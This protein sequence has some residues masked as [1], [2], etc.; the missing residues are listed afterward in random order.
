LRSRLLLLLAF[1]PALANAASFEVHPPAAWIDRISVDTNAA[2]PAD[3][4]SG[5]CVLLSDHQVRVDGRH[6]TEYF[7]RVRKVLTSSGV[8]NAS[9]ASLDFDPSYQHLIIHSATV[10]RDGKSTNV[11]EPGEVRI[12]EKESES[13]D[14]IYDGELT[15]V[16]FLKDVRPGDVIDYSWS[17][18]GANPLL[19]GR[20]ADEYEISSAMTSRLIRHRLLLASSRPLHYR[21]S[22]KG[23]SPRV[24][25]HGA[26]TEYVWERRDSQAVDAEDETPEWFDPWE[27][28]QVSEFAS[29]NEIARWSASLFRADAASA[30]AVRELAATIRAKHPSQSD[31]LVAAIRFV[32]DDIRYLGIEMGRN[33][34]E[35]HQPSL[36]LKQRY[37]DCKDKSF[38]L[39]LLLRE[40]GVE[41]YPALVNTRLRHRLDDYLPSPFL[42]DHVIVKVVDRAGIH[43]VDA[44]LSEQGGNLATIDTPNDER[45]LIVR[46]DTSSLAKISTRDGGSTLVEQTYTSRGAVTD[47]VVARTY[48]GADADTMRAHLAGLS[49]AD[50][51]KDDLNRFAVDHPQL[52][53]RGVPRISDDRQRNLV[54]IEE[55]YLV[56]DLWTN[57]SWSYV[58]RAITQYLQKPSTIVRTMPLAFD[59]PLDV[60]QRIVFHLPS[61]IELQTG[62]DE[63]ITHAFRVDSD[64]K[65]EGTTITIEHRLRSLA[66]A[67]PAAAVPRHLTQIGELVDAMGYDLTLAPPRKALAS[68]MPGV[69]A[70]AVFVVLAA[71]VLA[72]RR[73]RRRT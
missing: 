10:T 68:A 51:A 56:R 3:V 16:L 46:D 14:R 65:Q 50:L 9:E 38:L 25:T 67:V 69:G 22:L 44:T 53:A 1:L 26:E 27:T 5:I 52:E 40:L 61:T 11:L 34:H 57:G 64:V 58:P 73:R 29:W 19:G 7:R 31:Q 23:F 60:T 18:E 62:H 43:W 49:L 39:A 2:L 70:A 37:G 17:L 42:F 71:A 28:V 24:I 63:T 13:D 21:S 32:Q 4:R 20:Y 59:Y 54:V 72:T 48:R 45:A 66:D 12:I 35:P 36:T 47:L 33:S 8:Q 15:A 41:A 30:A 6:T 55:R